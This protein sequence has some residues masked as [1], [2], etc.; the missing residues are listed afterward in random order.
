MCKLGRCNHYGIEKR[1]FMSSWWKKRL[2]WLVLTT[3]AILTTILTAC[4]GNNAASSLVQQ[5]LRYPNVGTG[6]ISVLDPA[7]GPDANSNQAINL[8]F[9]GLV[10]TDKDQIDGLI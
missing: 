8:I 4:G 9:S 6:D 2:L 5:I 1:L 10:K 7:L 3:L